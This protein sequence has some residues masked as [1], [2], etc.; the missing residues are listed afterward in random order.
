MF[1]TTP[2]HFSVIPPPSV[3]SFSSLPKRQYQN[4]SL[5]NPFLLSLAWWFCFIP[6]MVLFSQYW[7]LIIS[8]SYMLINIINHRWHLR[9]YCA[10][11]IFTKRL[12]LVSIYLINV[13]ILICMFSMYFACLLLTWCC[14]CV[15]EYVR[16]NVCLDDEC[17]LSVTNLVLG[18][19]NPRP[20]ASKISPLI[21][22][23]FS[24]VNKIQSDFIGLKMAMGHKW[25]VKKTIL[26]DART[27]IGTTS[28]RAIH[29]PSGVKNNNTIITWQ[30]PISEL[31]SLTT[32]VL[33]FARC[34]WNKKKMFVF[35]C[36][37][38]TKTNNCCNDCYNFLSLSS[39]PCGFFRVLLHPNTMVTWLPP[40]RSWVSV[41]WP[42]AVNI[43]PLSLRTHYHET[44][45]KPTT[46]TTTPAWTDS[47]PS[48][49]TS[50]TTTPTPQTRPPM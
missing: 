43:P 25:D 26:H 42:F 15:C 32:R 27:V 46:T 14:A 9:N 50:W 45:T 40:L 12:L 11:S 48:P 39:Q 34:C 21:T 13:R 36:T 23:G 49:T 37:N 2:H 17:Y 29:V 7:T 35:C 38:E 4:Q 10:C 31:T 44:L 5:L 24:C 33:S 19:T 16:T 18:E 28:A 3:T 30:F 20:L 22:T 41:R 47:A 1:G 6:V 8:I